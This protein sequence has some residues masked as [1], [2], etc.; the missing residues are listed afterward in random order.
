[1]SWNIAKA[2]QQFSEV[3]RL[4]VQEPQAIYWHDKP[5]AA[6]ISAAD[7]EAFEQWRAQQRVA[8]LEQQFGEL[9]EALRE[10]GLSE[11]DGG[12]LPLPD[13]QAQQRANAF[14]DALDAESEPA[15]AAGLTTPVAPALPKKGRPRA[16]ATAV[17]KRR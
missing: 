5:V 10:A 12:L 7:F 9:R 13:R 8:P 1:M 6:L 2:K 14:A 3:V 11:G 17:R 4:S 15:P 16:A